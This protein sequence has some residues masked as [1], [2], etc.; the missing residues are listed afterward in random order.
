MKIEINLSPKKKQLKENEIEKW[1]YLFGPWAIKLLILG[2]ALNVFCFLIFMPLSKKVNLL[3]EE[4][5]KLKPQQEQINKLQEEIK[6]LSQE[7]EKYQN[8]AYFLFNPSRI[9]AALY[10]SLPENIWF[11]SLNYKERQLQITGYVLPWKEDALAS[12]DKFVNA[13]QENKEISS[14]F[15]N[16]KSQQFRK[17]TFNQQ[18]VIIFYIVCKE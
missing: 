13:L 17:T 7:K 16:I 3:K 14:V 4:E 8:K 11:E 5:K 18:D 15:K 9:L 10:T 1:F 12:L 6:Q 2:L